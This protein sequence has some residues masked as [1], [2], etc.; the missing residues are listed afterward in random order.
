MRS[1]GKHG[2]GVSSAGALLR[3][4]QLLIAFMLVVVPFVL[5]PAQGGA[6]VSPDRMEDARLRRPCSTVFAEAVI[7]AAP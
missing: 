3:A 2:I 7:A 6:P 4:C 1:N 5:L